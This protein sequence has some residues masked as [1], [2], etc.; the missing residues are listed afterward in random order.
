MHIVTVILIW[1]QFFQAL[2][3]KIRKG[4]DGIFLCFM[5]RGILDFMILLYDMLFNSV[6]GGFVT[7]F[8]ELSAVSYQL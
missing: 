3:G 5:K 7:S 2:P 4:S 8:D 6:Y 1:C